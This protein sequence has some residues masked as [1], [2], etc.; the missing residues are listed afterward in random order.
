MN[1]KI[2]VLSLL[3]FLIISFSFLAWTEKKQHNLNDQ[4]FLYFENPKNTKLDFVIENYTD[5]NTFEYLILENK[6]EIEKKVIQVAKREKKII[7]PT[8]NNRDGKIIIQVIHEKENKKIY[9][10]LP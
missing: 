3:L 10:I 1:Q 8:L 7:N 9:K 2:I 4:W 5:N 6:K